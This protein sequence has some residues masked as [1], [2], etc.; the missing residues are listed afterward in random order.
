MRSALAKRGITDDGDFEFY[1]LQHRRWFRKR[2]RAHVPGP[3][4]LA[5]DIRDVLDT[6]RPLKDIKGRFVLSNISK[7]DADALVKL[8]KDG[9]L[10]DVP[11]EQYYKRLRVDSE[12]LVR[13]VRMHAA[14][15]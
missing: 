13:A 10:S 15:A 4:E 11:G 2:V 9:Y 6:F 1:I 12:N 3:D 7:D 5:C 14:L 8:A